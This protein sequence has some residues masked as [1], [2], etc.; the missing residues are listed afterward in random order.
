MRPFAL[1]GFCYLLTL[2]AA[3]Y[4]GASLSLALGCV[5]L[6]CFCVLALHP[7]TRGYRVVLAALLISA[8]GFGSFSAYSRSAIQPAARL[9]GR[10]AVVTGTVCELPYR[11]Y[12]RFYYLLKVERIEAENAPRVEKIRLSAQNALDVDIYGTVRGRVHFFKPSGDDAG[13][14]SPAY[15]ASKGITLFAYLYEYEE[16][17]TAPPAA[18]PPYYYALEL[19][20][21]MLGSVR[22]LLPPGEADLVAGVLL[23]D[24]SGISEE[25]KSD[26]KTVGITHILS[27]SGLHM[28]TMSQLFLLLLG[29]F[30][31]PRRLSSA[32]AMAGVLAFMAVT[33]FV[34]SV[35]R[36]GIMC[37][38]FLAGAVFRRRA[39]SLNSLGT[40]VALL[41]LS[42]PYAAADL[43]LLLSFSATLGMILL[44][45][46]ITRRLRVWR[47]KIQHGRAL[48]DGA[49]SALATTVSATLFTLPIILLSFGTVSLVSPLANLLEVLPST[50]LMGFSALAAVLNL[51]E[52]TAFLAMPFALFSG[53][54]AKYMSF[55]AG[56]LAQIPYASVSAAYGFVRLWFAASLVLGAAAFARRKN[57]R[58]MLR[59]ASMLSV[60]LLL[61]GIF[62]YQLSMRNVTRVAVLKV[63]NGI[64]VALIQNGRGAVV[65]CSGFT[66]AAARTYLRGQGV[67]RLDYL[68][69]AGDSDEEYLAASELV[70]AFAPRDLLV[71]RDGAIFL[72]KALPYAETVHY[73]DGEAQ[74]SLWGNVTVTNVS[75]GAQVYTGI[76]V[77]GI[78]ILLCSSGCDAA[79]LPQKWREA[80]FAV[81]DDP[82]RGLA[83]LQ[84]M[85]TV[86]SMEEETLRQHL[87]S[88]DFAGVAACFTGDAGNFLIDIS[89]DGT[90]KL[91]REV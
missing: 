64:S 16:V 77:R 81:M 8:L 55:C 21:K 44:S 38:I 14:S 28:A 82:P 43:G 6:L 50:L 41:G 1:A 56:L 61:C 74:T 79:L 60:I 15:Y 73:F 59:A 3:V 87:A 68:Q 75:D 84:P 65:G 80:D 32:A 42:N 17:Q 12:G 19:R 36:S 71:R 23:G 26:F 40:A 66:S 52:Y 49:G 85:V 33:G 90:V 83:A 4:F 91:R 34:P 46:R 48:L 24:T 18:K 35:M 37:L 70:P 10:D 88:A 5:C 31:V 69:M 29:L 78:R 58:S 22:R 63:G 47:G 67:S 45:N 25:I 39:D 57:G 62:S 72:G 54:L 76:D 13:F 7:K 86:L 20:R 53:L 2:T 9:D 89:K 30:R 51:S 11:A 27:V